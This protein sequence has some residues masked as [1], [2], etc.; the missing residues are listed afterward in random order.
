M[1]D[2]NEEKN[3]ENNTIKFITI[4]SIYIKYVIADTECEYELLIE[5][6]DIL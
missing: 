6:G 1:R 2:I 3:K 5:M 4:T